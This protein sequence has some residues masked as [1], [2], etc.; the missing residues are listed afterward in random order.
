M[1]GN[2]GTSHGLFPTWMRT[3]LGPIM[4]MT[5]TP[6]AALLFVHA[7]LNPELDGSL[8]ALGNALLHKPLATL[9]AALVKPSRYS[10]QLLVAFAVWQL[11]LMRIVPGKEYRGPVTPSGNVPVYKANGLQCFF[12]TVFGFLLCSDY[13]LGLYP[14]TIIYDHYAEMISTMCIFSFMFCAMLNIKGLHFPSSSDSGSTGNRV[15]DFYWGT[16]LYPRILG[17]DVKMFTNCRYGRRF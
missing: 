1:W 17:W 11:L 16:E 7:N 4:L 10:I 13:G 5:A 14:A 12:I 2:K 3:T 8:A 15:L 6:M 9:A